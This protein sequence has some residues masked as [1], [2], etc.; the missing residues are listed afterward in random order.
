MRADVKESFMFNL[1][2]NVIF[3]SLLFSIIGIGYC[4][5]GRKNSMSFL[6]SGLALLLFPYFVDQL[7]V[8]ILLGLFF[9][10]LPFILQRVGV[11]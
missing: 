7:S 1:D 2:S 11:K 10:I 5:Y 3:L 8:L 9:V 4:S 6:L